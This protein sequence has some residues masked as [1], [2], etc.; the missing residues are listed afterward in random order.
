MSQIKHAQIRYRI[1][2]KMLRNEYKSFPTKE[3][4]RSACEDALFGGDYGEHICD[5]TIEKDLFAMRME[6]DA[7]IKYS[8]REKG[9]FYNDAAYSLDNIPLKQD[10]IDALKFAANTLFQFKEVSI[11]KQF[12]FAIN[13]ILDQINLTQTESEEDVRDF[14]QFE[15]G[16]TLRGSEFLNPLF[17]AIQDQKSV[18]FQ[19]SSFKDDALKGRKGVPLLLKEYRNRWYCL[20]F[21]LDKEK[22]ITYGLDRM[23][24]LKVGEV[25]GSIPIDFKP[26]NYFK[27][28]IGITAFDADPDTVVIKADNV[29]AKYIASQPIHS[30]QKIVK[31]G[32]K[33]T[34]FELKV[35]ITEELI[36]LLM[37]YGGEIEIKSPSIL[38][39]EIALRAQSMMEV[40]GS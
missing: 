24:D 26:S 5:S 29:A 27:H 14:V 22:V 3:E 7:P 8:K 31:E 33:R 12:D 32:K 30:S 13:K 38:R 4:L 16:N 21:D 37:S 39:D 9:Y 23:Y 35:L 34:T 20:C 36:R 6:L 11:F 1:I 17:Q 25:F 19:Y 10:E 28:S 40:Y 18:E 15:S 2:D